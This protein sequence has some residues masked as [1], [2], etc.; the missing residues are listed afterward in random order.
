M[1]ELT[2]ETPVQSIVITG[3]SRATGSCFDRLESWPPQT[4]S[5]L[6]IDTPSI[7]PRDLR[8]PGPM[9]ESE[10]TLK[11]AYQNASALSSILFGV[12]A[13]RSSLAQSLTCDVRIRNVPQYAFRW[14][15]H[16]PR[17]EEVKEDWLQTVSTRASDMTLAVPSTYQAVSSQYTEGKGR[18]KSS[19]LLVAGSIS[20]DGKLINPVTSEQTAAGPTSEDGKSSTKP[21][22][23]RIQVDDNVTEFVRRK[24][25][26]TFFSVRS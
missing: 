7:S 22:T 20:E 15:C 21:M 3:I 13:K 12:L 14:P 4:L 24:A 19:L 23:L 1:A 11:V 9:S 26:H 16:P 6:D 5:N 25:R 17:S 10:Q 2:S 18:S 8:V